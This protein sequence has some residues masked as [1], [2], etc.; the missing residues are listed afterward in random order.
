M[1]AEFVIANAPHFIEVHH[2]RW[3]KRVPLEK[4]GHEL[5]AQR[6][7]LRLR[8]HLDEVRQAIAVEVIPWRGKTVDADPSDKLGGS[9][10]D[11]VLRNDIERRQPAFDAVRNDV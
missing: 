5:L 4:Q 10:A 8:A 1:S 6:I 9:L 11:K 2:R 3:G 7:L